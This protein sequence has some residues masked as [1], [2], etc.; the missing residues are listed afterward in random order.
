[1]PS[2]TRTRS[3]PQRYTLY[4][5]HHFIAGISPVCPCRLLTSAAV[6]VRHKQ[7]LLAKPVSDLY[8]AL[9]CARVDLS[10]DPTITSM[11]SWGLYT[12]KEFQNTSLSG[13]YS[14]PTHSPAHAALSAGMLLYCRE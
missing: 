12:V 4:L 2:I 5:K 10:S 3:T 11:I 8:Y 7:Q 14:S 1:M 9:P 13:Q 6:T